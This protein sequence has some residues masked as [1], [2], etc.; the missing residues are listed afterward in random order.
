MIIP[1]V[2]GDFPTETNGTNGV[3]SVIVARPKGKPQREERVYD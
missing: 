3:V 1:E 2:G